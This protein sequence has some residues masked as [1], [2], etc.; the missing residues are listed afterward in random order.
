MDA[1][2]VVLPANGFIGHLPHRIH[3]IPRS[4]GDAC[5]CMDWRPV[6]VAVHMV[7]F[8]DRRGLLVQLWCEL[9]SKRYS[10]VPFI[11]YND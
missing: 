1:L 5:P 11:I 9:P 3:A 6:R 10:I 4:H 7:G 2:Q 8:F